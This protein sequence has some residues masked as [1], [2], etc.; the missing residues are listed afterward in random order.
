ERE[1]VYPTELKSKLLELGLKGVE[2]TADE[3]F[4]A[5]DL[6]SK[7]RRLSVFDRIALA[8][9]KKRDITLLV[10]VIPNQLK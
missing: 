10:L 3:L 7:Y 2:I 5:D 9:A 8:I 6:S 1:L 4:Y